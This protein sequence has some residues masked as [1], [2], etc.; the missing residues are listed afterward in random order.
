MSSL[1][2]GIDVGDS[3][4]SKKKSSGGPDPKVIKGVIAGVLFLVA[5]AVLA[6]QF[7][8]IPSPFGGST[9]DGVGN[10]I[11]Y[12][13]QVQTEAE[14]K[15]RMERLQREEEEYIRRGGVVGGA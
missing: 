12:Q 11:E 13:P 7:G 4:G 2:D 6:M 14:K 3:G 5:G 15:E 1:L 8:L 10:V 9:R